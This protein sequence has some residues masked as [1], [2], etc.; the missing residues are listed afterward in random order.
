M[1][2]NHFSVVTWSNLYGHTHRCCARL[3]IKIGL[4][5]KV[6]QNDVS[7]CWPTN[8]CHV[9]QKRGL[10]HVHIL[11]KFPHDCLHPEDI[12]AV[13]SAEIP[14]DIEDAALVRKFMLHHHPSS[15]REPSKYCPFRSFS[16][17]RTVNG[18]TFPSFQEAATKRG[19]FLDH[20]EASL[21][22]LEATTTLHTPAQL[23]L[24]VDLLVN[25]CITMP[26]LLWQD[27]IDH[28][29]KDFTICH[30]NDTQLAIY[31]TLRDLQRLLQDHDKSL[32]MYGLPQPPERDIETVA[33]IMRWGSHPNDLLKHAQTAYNNFTEDQRHIFDTIWTAVENQDPLLRYLDGRAGTGKST[34]ITT[35]CDA[36]RGSG[37]VI[38]PTAS[39]AFAAQL[40]PGGRTTHSTCKVSLFLQ[41][42]L[43]PFTSLI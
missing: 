39:S 11:L 30:H 35:L 41:T 28:L 31:F 13:I 3:Q 22:M 43:T 37:W 5:F 36:I 23:H 40:Y 27:F 14:N 8:S 12:D 42:F 29:S 32:S 4:T 16:D 25:D 15:S 2:R 1:A 6:P 24:F 19:L 33:E 26:F 34:V 38:L 9:F 21:A 10:P 18:I 7:K 17:A 20:D